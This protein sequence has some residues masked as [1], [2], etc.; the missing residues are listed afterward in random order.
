MRL[1]RISRSDDPRLAAVA[2]IY[3]EA[4]PKSERKPADWI[5][6]ATL[7]EDFRLTVAMADETVAGFSLSFVPAH[8]DFVLVEYLAV[9]TEH[10]GRGV[11]GCLLD[12]V[13]ADRAGRTVLAEVET[14]DTPDRRRR[15][16]FYRRRGC[17]AVQGLD[18][19]LPLHPAA[20]PPPMQLLAAYAPPLLPR[21]Q[22][23]RWLT[24]IYTDVYAMPADDPRL[25]SMLSPLADSA[26]FD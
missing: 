10:R 11:G 14:A 7:R 23:R 9:K 17:R 6:A 4:I 21:V 2:A 15:H 5:S 26:R 1:D 3:V 20:P 24:R 22:L 19:L 16:A 18:Y 12:A 8:N 13:I 25:E